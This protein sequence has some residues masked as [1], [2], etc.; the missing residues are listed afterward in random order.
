MKTKD[1]QDEAQRHA[2]RNYLIKEV[3]NQLVS[4]FGYSYT[5]A[6]IFIGRIWGLGERKIREIAGTK[7]FSALSADDLSKLAVILQRISKTTAN[8]AGA[9]HNY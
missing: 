2:Q 8:T 1:K 9:S 7:S 5:D 3:R 6:D 4:S